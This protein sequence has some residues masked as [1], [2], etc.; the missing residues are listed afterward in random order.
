MPPTSR[1]GW[2]SG[3]G[4]RAASSSARSPGCG[5]SGCSS[6]TGVPSSWR[7]VRGG[8]L[9]RVGCAVCW[10][11]P[12]RC[13]CWPSVAARSSPPRW[14]PEASTARSSE[15]GPAPRPSAWRNCSPSS[16]VC[17]S[18]PPVWPPQS[19]PGP[20]TS[21]SPDARRR[22]RAGCR[23]GGTRPGNVRNSDSGDVLDL[24]GDLV[25]QVRLR[26]GAVE[27]RVR[28]GGRRH[29]RERGRAV[30]VAELALAV[31]GLAASPAAL[32]R[33]LAVGE[34]EVL[35]GDLAVLLLDREVAGNREVLQ[36]LG[37][38]LRRGLDP[39]VLV[40]RVPGEQEG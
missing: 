14:R 10:V 7:G 33:S 38:Q 21:S 22:T 39:L 29:R 26:V 34:V 13:S 24:G 18:A 23:R 8:W 40:H 27:T 19:L 3:C 37:A 16:A 11:R 2:R 35:V 9:T 30:V 31:R 32:T 25:H 15:A 4:C 17:C 6:R 36:A 1:T 28:D 20:G 12:W 5:W